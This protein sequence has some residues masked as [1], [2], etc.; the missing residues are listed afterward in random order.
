MAETLSISENLV[1][2]SNLP[3][4]DFNNIP[5]G[6][7]YTDHMFVADYVDGQWTDLRIEAYGNMSLSPANM[8]LHYGQSIF[9]GMKAFKDADGN[10]LMFRPEENA[11]R[12]NRSAERMCMPSIPEEIFLSGLKRLLEIDGDWVP[13]LEG[14]ALYIR[15]YMFAMDEY[16]GL[17][18]SLNYRFMI[19]CCPVG[20]YY[21]QPVSVKVEEEYSRAASGG[22][23]EAKAAGNYA[24]SLYPARLAQQQGYDQLIWTDSIEHKYIEEA[25]TM[26]LMFVMDGE[27]YSPALSGTILPGITRASVLQVAEEWGVKVHVGRL[28]VETVIEAHRA[29]KLQ[30]VFGVGT[31]V[32]VSSIC[33]I[34]F[35][36][37]DF[38]LDMEN[39]ELSQKIASYFESIRY[40]KQE[41]T[42]GWIEKV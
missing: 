5:F 7:V 30:E 18:P 10:V 14:T 17:K 40:G 9:E 39:R 6:R 3:Q 38:E 35:R 8:A 20:A 25:G 2:E 11:K 34:G 19:F 41:D 28:A 23:G 32:T 22:T 16:V 27:L 1:A 24:G 4:V 21:S 26:N 31:A 29:G 33:R 36:G 15:P 12:L 42:H 13:N 37:E